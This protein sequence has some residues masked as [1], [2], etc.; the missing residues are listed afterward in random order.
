ML[1]LKT[2]ATDLPGVLQH[3]KRA[4]DDVPDALPGDLV[5]LAQ[6]KPSLAPD[7]KPIRWVMTFVKCVPDRKRELAVW[8]HQYRY[9]IAGRDVREVRPFDLKD[10]QVSI[11]DYGAVIEHCRV[12]PEDERAVL[13]WIGAEA[14]A[15]RAAGGGIN[16]RRSAEPTDTGDTGA[17]V[18][19][20]VY[21]RWN[22]AV[23]QRFFS[24]AARK[25]PVYLDVDDDTIQELGEGLGVPPERAKDQFRQ[26]VADTLI[27][28]PRTRP[29]LS[30]HRVRL[31]SWLESDR[32][33]T[34]PFLALLALFCN[35]AE[36]MKRTGHVA[37]HNYYTP[38]TREL[39]LPVTDEYRD[40]VQSGFREADQLWRDLNRWLEHLEGERGI[41]T[42]NP[43]DKRVHIGFPL[44]QALLREKDRRRLPEFFTPYGLRPQQEMLPHD[45]ERL[46]A[47]WVPRSS[48]SAIAKNLW[49]RSE[50]RR[51]MAEI[52]S[53]ELAS[54]DGSQ[55]AIAGPGTARIELVASFVTRPR[56]RVDFAAVVRR[57]A[58]VP[59]GVYRASPPAAGLPLEDGSELDE[60]ILTAGL[61]SEWF[62]D[63]PRVSVPDLLR[64]RVVLT[65]PDGSLSVEWAPRRI[66][67]FERDE[68]MMRFRSQAR[69]E[70]NE[71]SMLLVE[72]RL[73][74]KVYAVLE[75]VALPELAMY[76]PAQVEGLPE[77]WRLLANVVLLALPDV[78]EDPDLGTLVPYSWTSL[79]FS[80]GLSVPGIGT[81]LTSA[82]PVLTVT[83]VLDDI[84]ELS[85]ETDVEHVLGDERWQPPA[86]TVSQSGALAVDLQ[87]LR[88]LDGDYRLSV[89]AKTGKQELKV[90]SRSLRA[91]SANHLRPAV[92]PTQWVGHVLSDGNPWGAVSAETVLGEPAEHYVR[93]ACIIGEGS[94]TSTAGSPPPAGLPEALGSFEPSEPEDERGPSGSTT[95]VASGDTSC[96]LGAHYFVLPPVTTI[97][98]FGRPSKG[99]CKDCGLAKSF[100]GRPKAS[101][102]PPPLPALRQPRKAE[103]PTRE[104]VDGTE[105]RGTYDDLLDATCYVQSGEWGRFE[106]L[107]S[108]LSDEPWFASET[109]R[110][111]SALGHIDIEFDRLTLRPKRWAVAPA[112]V[113]VL[114][115]E[116]PKA[117]LAGFRSRRLTWSVAEAVR[118]WG[119]RLYVER[120][121]DG[122]AILIVDGLEPGELGEVVAL[123][124]DK[125]PGGVR[126]GGP[127]G[128]A[129]VGA[130]PPI[131][132]VFHSLPEVSA[133]LDIAAKKFEPSSAKWVPAED[134]TADGLYQYETRPVQFVLRAHGRCVRVESRVGKHMA[135]AASRVP[136]LAYDRTT[137]RLACPMGARLP[138]LY[139]RAAVLCSGRPPST[140]RDDGTVLY[141]GVPPS[142]AS[143]LWSL[144]SVPGWFTP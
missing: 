102:G 103:R 85:V 106:F 71:P 40:H 100:P 36:N 27:L 5:L 32:T 56:P 58:D 46:M 25:R 7:E 97:Q 45:M 38:L 128:A 90:A 63:L 60:V 1:L 64:R 138:G 133:P 143:G 49:K 144:L 126:V 68:A 42:A 125:V 44:S 130:L 119:G 51:R 83:S 33:D 87:S 140:D 10:V 78:D 18:P 72:E 3:T 6:T 30:R 74:G 17:G 132:D 41:P 13:D 15:G 23:A 136:M 73:A 86:P 139:E 4:S 57:R 107:A 91:R 66:V 116:T 21:D 141:E 131:R 29:L 123:V 127:V 37:P 129:F 28:Q 92:G 98:G 61:Y 75:G 110:L 82:L 94:K 122:P 124:D 99:I 88:L 16:E 65:T 93:G 108:Q 115:S 12:L 142:V 112:T 19:W 59:E 89:A 52:A 54:W 31:R 95:P 70:L 47:D 84:V 113:V 101:R 8:G 118:A 22:E 111:L 114:P 104:T 20:D 134:T 2:S 62:E 34:P 39:G 53:V 76:T 80:G 69:L 55:T 117:V 26:A 81:W 120:S 67:V 77:G 11:K 137:E 43:L 48:L 24:P 14:A 135:A 35:V 109:A 105:D 50:A 96:L 9:L 79:T 121:V